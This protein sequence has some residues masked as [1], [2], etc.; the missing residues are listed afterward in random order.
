MTENST[1]Q[2]YQPVASAVATVSLVITIVM[3]WSHS[4]TQSGQNTSKVIWFS[5]YCLK[6]KTDGRWLVRRY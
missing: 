4:L 6:E 5:R 1:S 2:V 3:S